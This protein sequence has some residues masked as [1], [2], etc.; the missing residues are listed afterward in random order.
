MKVFQKV[1][2][3]LGSLVIK[4]DGGKDVLNQ[5]KISM[6]VSTVVILVFFM[7]L[8]LK[9]CK[10]SSKLMTVNNGTAKAL[11]AQNEKAQSPHNKS[12]HGNISVH[13]NTNTHG[14]KGSP[15]VSQLLKSSESEN[16]STKGE[17]SSTQGQRPKT[18]RRAISQT[19]KA[20]AATSRKHHSPPAKS[21]TFSIK[22]KAPQVIRRKVSEGGVMGLPLG[23][24]IKGRLLTAIDTRETTQLYK[25]LLPEGGQDK[26]GSFI[27]RNSILF[28]TVRYPG[29][30]KKVFMEFTKILLPNGRE[31][32]I[33]AQALH[34]KDQ[35]PGLVGDFHGQAMKKIA[36]T[37]GLGVLSTMTE[38]LTKKEFHGQGAHLTP[39]ATARNAFYQ[40]VS[41]ASQMEAQR[42]ANHMGKQPEYVTL[43]AG[44]KIIV[45]LLTTYYGEK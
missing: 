19:E 11:F 17:E 7:T 12:S 21:E 22:Y 37:L 15:V 23:T 5:R 38:T 26:N 18:F 45:N 10:D 28:G 16:S 41:K 39:R 25:V 32:K 31:G 43:P 13:A 36:S 14:T 35:S 9:S 29:Q 1:L 44:Q 6:A 4:K 8:F 42:R 24:H 3:R 33:H 2:H 30:G 27:P 40:G 20:Q 34:P